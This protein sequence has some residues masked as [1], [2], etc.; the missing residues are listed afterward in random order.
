[1]QHAHTARLL[2]HMCVHVCVCVC[3]HVC[4][5]PPCSPCPDLQGPSRTGLPAPPAL[6]SR[7]LRDPASVL[8]LPRAP[9]AFENRP[10]CSSCPELQGPS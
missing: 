10:P 3:V 4:P 1:M 2:S 5:R 9:G 8:P 7:G 6:S